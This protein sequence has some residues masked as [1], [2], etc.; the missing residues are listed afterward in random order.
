[1]VHAAVRGDALQRGVGLLQGLRADLHQGRPVP[2][3]GGRH[4]LRLQLLRPR[5][6][7]PGDGPVG[8]QGVHVAGGGAAH[9]PHVHL[10]PH[11]PHRRAGGHGA[12]VRRAGLQPDLCH[13][14][15]L[16]QPPLRARGAAHLPHHQAGV[17]CLGV[18]HLPHLPRWKQ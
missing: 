5:P 11:L 15:H 17:R 6:L 12:S 14:R 1:M 9:P 13:H 8:V 7:R 16:H 18:G 10:L 3:H 4:H 2:Q